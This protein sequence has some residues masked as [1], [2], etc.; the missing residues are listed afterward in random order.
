M[1]AERLARKTAENL[2][3][4]GSLGAVLE[5]EMAQMKKNAVR[6]VVQDPDLTAV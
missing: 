1:W 2:L 5:Y 3:Q 6:L 4:Y